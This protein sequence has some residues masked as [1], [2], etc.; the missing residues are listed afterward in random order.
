VGRRVVAATEQVV[1]RAFDAVLFDGAYILRQ[2][3]A[4]LLP[5]PPRTLR[6]L[7]DIFRHDREHLIRRPPQLPLP[8]RF[9]ERAVFPVGVR[10]LAARDPVVRV[11]LPL[12]LLRGLGTRQRAITLT[13][14]SHL[15]I[16]AA[17][18]Q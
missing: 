16:A 9:Y 10:I 14:T 2:A 17:Q 15:G 7:E 18:P 6:Q 1:R 13:Y 8:D 11:G 5:G 4:G 12:L 3:H